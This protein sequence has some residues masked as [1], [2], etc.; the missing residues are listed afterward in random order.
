MSKMLIPKRQGYWLCEWEDE[1]SQF[2]PEGKWVG[3]AD[4]YQRTYRIWIPN[5]IAEEDEDAVDQYIELHL[6]DPSVWQD[7]DAWVE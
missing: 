4:Y 5:S 6:D 3:G 1:T 2:D 7:P